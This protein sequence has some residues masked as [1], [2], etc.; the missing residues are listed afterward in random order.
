M[1]GRFPNFTV[2]TQNVD[3]LHARA[4]TRSLIELHGNIW[5]DRCW[6]NPEHTVE[7]RPDEA[8]SLAGEAVPRCHCGARLRPD[9]VWFGENLDPDRLEAAMERASAAEVLLVV[10]TSSIVYPAAALPALARRSGAAVIEVNPHET[11][12]SEGMDVVLRGPAGDVLPALERL[13]GGGSSAPADTRR[14]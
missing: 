7:R 2:I 3:G 8:D 11:A 14:A 9:V 10:G 4:G 1:E 6:D 13:S 5:R 12:L